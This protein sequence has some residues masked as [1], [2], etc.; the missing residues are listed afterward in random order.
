MS[1]NDSHRLLTELLTEIG[2]ADLQI[3]SPGG[4]EERVLRH[5][6]RDAAARAGRIRRRPRT[7]GW[8]VSCAGALAAAMLLLVLVHRSSQG[9][10]V[11]GVPVADPEVRAQPKAV[12]VPAAAAVPP[13]VGPRPITM[14][15]VEAEKRPRRVESPSE[16]VS[17]VPLF[18]EAR[19]D[20][21]GSFQVA[22]VL[23]PREVLA[24]LGVVPDA[25]RV[26]GPIQADVVFGEDGLARAIR[27]ADGNPGRVQ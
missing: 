8:L 27:L 18:P 6:D 11:A 24:D 16:I 19:Q 4:L 23:L 26:G 21:L 2:G 17:F 7:P 10:I 12:E 9:P 14:A 20:L 15:R 3:N 13:A 25:S 22:R 5:W 1:D